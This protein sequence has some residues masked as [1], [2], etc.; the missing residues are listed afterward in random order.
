MN[1]EDLQDPKVLQSLKNQGIGTKEHFAV[2]EFVLKFCEDTGEEAKI[3]WV[4]TRDATWTVSLPVEKKER[5]M[6]S[7]ATGWGLYLLEAFDDAARLIRSGAVFAKYDRNDKR[8]WQWT[9]K[10]GGGVDRWT[11]D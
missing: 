1:R 2:L 4:A 7:G 10:A 8:R 6:R 9:D 11:E 3:D 5:G